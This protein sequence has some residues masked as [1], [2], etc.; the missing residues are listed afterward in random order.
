[1]FNKLLFIFTPFQLHVRYARTPSISGSSNAL[2]F[3]LALFQARNI[4][5]KKM[6][7]KSFINLEAE[8]QSDLK[9]KQKMLKV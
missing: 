2:N 9:E 7:N 6:K 8:F 1:M 5:K 4:L 3:Q